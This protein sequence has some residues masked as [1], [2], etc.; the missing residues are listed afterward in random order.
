LAQTAAKGERAYI[1]GTAH[2]EAHRA[3]REEVGEIRDAGGARCLQNSFPESWKLPSAAVS[4]IVRGEK[5]TPDKVREMLL[6]YEDLVEY[7]DAGG[8]SDGY[9]EDVEDVKY[10]EG[11]P[12]A[13]PPTP[14]G[15]AVFGLVEHRIA[16]DKAIDRLHE[17]Q[18]GY[19]RELTRGRGRRKIEDIALAVGLPRATFDYQV[20]ACAKKIADM[21][22]VQ[23]TQLTRGEE[24]SKALP[25]D[26][27]KGHSPR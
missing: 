27:L 17:P 3:V 12:R 21:L 16:L 1:L 19:M 14:D 2:E 22:R 10:R 18:R 20:C 8:S 7:I 24:L 9:W 26:T 13:R 6:S 25:P 11:A 5:Y 15:H 23:P 4:Y